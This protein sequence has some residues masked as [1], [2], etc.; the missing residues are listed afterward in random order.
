MNY[1][2][3]KRAM[4][5]VV[6]ATTGAFKSLGI[7]QKDFELATG[8]APWLGTDRRRVR[9]VLDSLI[10]ASVDLVGVNRFE[11]SAEYIAA[12]LGVFVHP[13]NLMVACRFMEG[14]S[15]A[16]AHSLDG[17]ADPV[18]A[19]QLHALVIRLHT[20]ESADS[21]RDQFEKTVK[22]K[23]AAAELRLQQKRDQGDTG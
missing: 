16:E 14:A 15:T 10:F 2:V 5:L 13:V 7:S 20:S 11:V 19:D 1:E 3:A 4:M 21:A 22:Q 9:S 12:C 23:I 18:T 17:V 6:T 8:A